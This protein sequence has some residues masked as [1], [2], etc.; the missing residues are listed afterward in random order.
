MLH[1][2]WL[3]NHSL[4]Q[5]H[6][7]IY[8]YFL[9]NFRK[10]LPLT[11]KIFTHLELDLYQHHHKNQFYFSR[12]TTD[13]SHPHS[14]TRPTL[15]SATPCRLSGPVELCCQFLSCPSGPPARPAPTP[16]CPHHCCLGGWEPSL[17]NQ[18]AIFL[19]NNLLTPDPLFFSLIYRISSSSSETC[20]ESEWHFIELIINSQR[21]D[22]MILLIFQFMNTVLFTIYLL[23]LGN[24]Q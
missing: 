23:S 4:S 11:F 5:N 18:G 16:L 8:L 14:L 19:R 13:L 15:T 9:L 7:S 2:S 3:R 12:I 21:N 6:K 1:V 20:W 10:L 17:T 24:F 22:S